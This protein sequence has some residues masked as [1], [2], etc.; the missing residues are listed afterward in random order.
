MPDEV[1]STTALTVV[2]RAS[3]ALGAA[4]REKKLA[5]MAAASVGITVITNAAGLQECHAARMVLKNERVTIEKSGKAARD[6]ARAFADAVIQEERRLIGI[7]RPEEERLEA[8]QA[9]HE[10]KL[11]ADKAER[12]RIERERVAAIRAKID[13]IKARATAALRLP[14]AEVTALIESM[15]AV[16]DTFAELAAEA[17]NVRAATLD[18]LTELR[19]TKTA[20]EAEA[21]R[22]AAERAEFDRQ[23]QEQARRDAEAREAL[24]RQQEADAAERKRLDDEAAAQRAEQDRIAREAREREEAERRRVDGIRA[25]IAEIAAT[26]TAEYVDAAAIEAALNRLINNPN[27]SRTDFAELGPEAET[28]LARAIAALQERLAAR[29][30]LEQQE[31]ER[32]EAEAR[33]AEE[34]RQEEARAA[35]ARTEEAQRESARRAQLAID[36]DPWT[37]LADIFIAADNADIRSDDF[38]V[39][40]RERISRAMDARDELDAIEGVDSFK[41]WERPGPVEKPAKVRRRKAVAQVAA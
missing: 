13:S 28:A 29:R 20:Q 8:L 22:L 31:R 12:E 36:A 9:A 10:A 27:P 18:Y 24:R 25:R 7:I 30:I 39:A 4:E 34:R 33:A 1:S 26:A 41:G 6:D 17:A 21:A 40:T 15:P 38:R 32:Q 11:A 14:A 16:D 19:D 23:Q 2:Q 37:L 3:A 5:A 35:A